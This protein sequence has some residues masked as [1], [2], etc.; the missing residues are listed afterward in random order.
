[1]NICRFSNFWMQKDKKWVSRS[2]L[3]P[4]PVDVSLHPFPSISVVGRFKRA[5]RQGLWKVVPSESFSFNHLALEVD[6]CPLVRWS[7]GFESTRPQGRGIEKL[8]NASLEFDTGHVLITSSI[9]GNS[10]MHWCLTHGSCPI[11]CFCWS[12]DLCDVDE[13]ASHRGSSYQD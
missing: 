6:L 8:S 11:P 7:V 12:P 9:S 2:V 10:M 4:L 1:M 3:L 5:F 13:T